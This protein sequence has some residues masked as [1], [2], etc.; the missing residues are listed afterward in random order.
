VTG[1]RTALAGVA[2]VMLAGCALFGDA[3][4]DRSCRRNTDCFQAQGEVCDEAT[5]TCIVPDFDAAVPPPDAADLP[6]GGPDGG[7]DAATDATPDSDASLDAA[8][9]AP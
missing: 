3:Y 7:P 6:D 5:S 8:G 4:P 1:R 2:A 9:V